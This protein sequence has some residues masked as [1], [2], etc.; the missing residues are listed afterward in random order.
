MVCYV[1]PTLAAA[2][3]YAHRKKDGRTDEE[4]AQLNLLLAGGA[5][6]GLVDHWWNGQLFWSP[7]IGSDLMLGVL[8]TAAIY[9]VWFAMLL[10]KQPA[11]SPAVA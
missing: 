2:M 7:S 6:F 3:V 11:R 1:L 8:I 5:V 9:A 4:G 10:A